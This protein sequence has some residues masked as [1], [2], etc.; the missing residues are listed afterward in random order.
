MS[1][2]T[3]S[4]Y[5]NDGK[6]EAN[7]ILLTPNPTFDFIS[8]SSADEDFID[9]SMT[10]YNAAGQLI[11]IPFRDSFYGYRIFDVS[12]LPSGVYFISLELGEEMVTKKF[13]KV[14]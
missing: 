3:E 8:L 2:P 4:E 10:V 1:L 5:V 12:K 9:V 13:I 7:D 11:E 6:L 14:D